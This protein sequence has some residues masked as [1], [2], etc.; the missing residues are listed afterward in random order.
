MRCPLPMLLGAVKGGQDRV[1]AA[2]LRV[3]SFRPGRV[4]PTRP[5][6]RN[7]GIVKD[8]LGAVPADLEASFALANQIAPVLARGLRGNPRQLKRFLS[9]SSPCA[10]AP[11]RPARSSSTPRCWRS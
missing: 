9:T 4:P 3:A 10:A 5:A 8:V 6:S 1:V 2:D 7:C 11:R